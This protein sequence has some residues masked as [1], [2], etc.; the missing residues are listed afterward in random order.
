M[1]FFSFFKIQGYYERTR[2]FTHFI[3]PELFKI[4]TLTM[5]GFVEK[6]LK[7]VTAT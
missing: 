7:F 3:K 2:Q 6:L 5:H 1:G 4:S